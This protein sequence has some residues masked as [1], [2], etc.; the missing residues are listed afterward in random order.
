ML[1][2]IVVG[3]LAEFHIHRQIC[4]TFFPGGPMHAREIISK[5]IVR[6]GS[7]LTTTLLQTRANISENAPYAQGNQE[8][9]HKIRDCKD[10][11]YNPDQEDQIRGLVED[12][13]EEENIDEAPD[14]GFS[15]L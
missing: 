5:L 15:D 3:L 11:C 10:L 7:E 1:N 8:A 2:H 4:S 12:L 14:G 13:R 9:Q 6:L